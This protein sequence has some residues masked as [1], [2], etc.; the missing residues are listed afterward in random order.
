MRALGASPQEIAEAQALLDAQAQPPP[1]AQDFG[2]WEENWEAFAFFCSLRTQW[3]HLVLPRTVQLPMGGATT[4]TEVRRECLPANRVESALRL[5]GIARARWPRLFADV[6]LMESAVL[7]QD[8]EL[9]AAR[10]RR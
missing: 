6:W 5:Q 10:E 8:A 7:E 1:A 2:V 9:A 3:T 4:Y